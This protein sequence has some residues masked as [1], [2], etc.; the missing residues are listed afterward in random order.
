MEK[1]NCPKFVLVLIDQNDPDLYAAIKLFADRHAGFKTVICTNE[2]VPQFPTPQGNGMQL[3]RA[4][5]GLASLMSNLALKFNIKCGGQNH[6]VAEADNKSASGG[7]KHAV[8]EAD[9]KSA[10]APLHT[11]APPAPGKLAMPG[12][13]G[14]VQP[15]DPNHTDAMVLGVDVVHP[16]G[17]TP[18]IAAMVGTVDS[19]FANFCGSVRLQPGRV[20]ILT[21]S[22][23]QELFTER[24]AAFKAKTGKVPKRLLYYR[25][26]V[27]EDQYYQVLSEE[28]DA[29]QKV[30]PDIAITAIVVGKRHHTRFFCVKEKDTYNQG[31]ALS[32]NAKPGLL[33]DQVITQP[34]T[35]DGFKDFFLQSHAAI[36]GTAKSAHYIVIRNDKKCN[37][38]M[39]AI[40][41]LTHAFCYNY[42]R[43]TKGVSYCAPAYYADRL[44]DRMHRLL[45]LYMRAHDIGNWSMSQSEQQMIPKTAG[46]LAFRTRIAQEID[47]DKNW[48]PEGHSNPW[49]PAMDNIM[50]WL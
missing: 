24:L 32:G 29:I 16:G 14:R 41:N 3:N 47:D 38:S 8:A 39:P 5:N 46:G 13:K 37:L 40:Y 26:G 9:N 20:E 19:H 25:D 44:C 22:N 15:T 28:V 42:A 21:K 7:Q 34:D 35:Q 18:S 50:F 1:A 36:R 33:V 31:K 23:M 12:Q 43:A 48:K 30:L 27:S 17:D 10:F 11:A 6:T 45:K 2:K 4:G 49:H